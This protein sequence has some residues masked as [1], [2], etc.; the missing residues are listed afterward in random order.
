MR[1]LSLSLLALGAVLAVVATAGARALRPS[2]RDTAAATGFVIHG[3]AR[4]LYPGG[5]RRLVI[6]IA[7]PQPTPIRVVS[8]RVRVLAAGIRCAASNVHVGRFRRTLT[9]GAR[10]RGSLV[11]P[12]RMI[13]VAPNGCQGAQFPLLFTGRAVRP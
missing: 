9:I 8:I 4:G 2:D 1:N 6:R 5:R 13:G 10:E 3:S 12:I 7:N 11:L